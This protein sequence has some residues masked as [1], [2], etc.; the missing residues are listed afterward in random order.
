MLRLLDRHPHGERLRGLLRRFRAEQLSLI[1]ALLDSEARVEAL[2]RAAATGSESHVRRCRELQ[3]E[4][5]VIRNELVHVRMAIAGAREEL[6][7][8]SPRRVASGRCGGRL[9]TSA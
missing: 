1:A 9:V 2:H 7:L 6:E 4:C 8:H 3:T 5:E